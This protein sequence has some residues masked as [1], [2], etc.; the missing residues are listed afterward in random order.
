MPL[1][2]RRKI[3]AV[4]ASRAKMH[5]SVVIAGVSPLFES[6]AN[7]QQATNI[8]KIGGGGGIRTPGELA[9]PT[10]FK[11]AAI[12]HSATPPQVWRRASLMHEQRLSVNSERSSLNCHR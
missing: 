4:G 3:F 9:P 6:F 12:D 11:T 7:A 8:C 2:P 1:G 10:V 5:E